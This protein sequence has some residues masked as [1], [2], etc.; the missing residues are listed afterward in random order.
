[1]QAAATFEQIAARLASGESWTGELEMRRRDGSTFAGLIVESPLSDDDGKIIGSVGVAY[2]LTAQ[3]VVQDELREHKVQLADAQEIA[4]IGSWTFDFRTGQRHWSDAL[5]QLYGLPPGSQPSIEDLFSLIHP[6][7]R[8]RVIEVHRQSH[9]D[10]LPVTVEF[11]II[12]NGDV[13]SIVTRVRFVR[14]ELGRPA[15][16]LVV[17]QDVTEERARE[18]ELRRRTFQQSAVANLGQLALSG[19]SIEFLLEQVAISVQSVVDV[20]VATVLRSDDEVFLLV[21]GAGWAADEIGRETIPVRARSHSALTIEAGHPI[22]MPDA[23]T[24][25]RFTLSDALR[26]KGAVSGIFVPIHSADG[27]AW[28][29]LG[30][31]ATRSRAY[32]PH[33]VEFLTAVSSIIGQAIDRER[34][35]LELRTRS[36]RQSAI[37]RLGQLVL[38]DLSDDV[39]EHA[40]E[41]MM[42]GLE[43][44]FG[45]F[46][47]VLPG[48]RWRLR[49]GKIWLSVESEGPLLPSMQ[50]GEAFL[51]SAA[52]VVDDYTTDTRFDAAARTVPYGI[53]SGLVVPVSSAS[54][55]FGVLSVQSR[56]PRHFGQEEVDFAQTIAHMLAEAM[57][58]QLSRRVIEESEHRYRRIF[59]GAK[60]I[61]FTLDYEGRFVALNPA[62]ETLTGWDRQEWIGRPFVELIVPEDRERS[63]ALFESMLRER[64]AANAQM[65]LIGSDRLV[66]VD[67]SS[68]PKTDNGAITE[69][70]GFARD[71]TDTRRATAERERVTRNLELLL[72]STVDGIYTLDM[73][74][75]CTMINRAAAAMLQRTPEELIG[76]KLHDL[77]HPMVPVSECAVLRVLQTAEP[78]TV[79]NDSFVKNDG[80]TFP[81]AHSAAP[82]ID[83]GRSVGVVVTFTD[84]SET[85][86]LE[87][88]LD[89]ANRLSSLG[90]LAA[91]VAHEFNNVL[92]GIAP[93]IEVI[94]RAPTPQKIEAS[95][96]HIANSVKRG[97]RITQDIL[98]FTQPAEPVRARVDVSSWLNAVAIEARSVLPPI[99]SLS[100][101]VER[102]TIE[103]DANQLHQVVMNLVLNA[104]D[105]MPSGGR[106]S[107]EARR[108][109]RNASFPFGTIQ[110]P[111]GY[112]HLLVRDEGMGMSPETLH[113]AFEPLFTTKRNGTGLGL[114]VTHQVVLR[115]QGEIFIESAVGEGT[116]FHIFLPLEEEAVTANAATQDELPESLPAR[117]LLLVED[118]TTV[119]EGL[120]SLLELEGFAVEKADSGAEALIQVGAKPFDV[121]LLDVGLPD[122]DGRAVYA[123]IAERYPTLPVIFSTGHADR[124]QLEALLT[125]P[126][127]DMLL[128]PYEI[129]SLMDV[130]GK[131]M[132]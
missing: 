84:L 106:I 112:V 123:R 91:T 83:D 21:A 89:Q 74:G 13:R 12:R 65:T 76:R 25:T 40:C 111:S 92:M 16:A 116:T 47:D 61:I 20:D 56:K 4:R 37:A 107:I 51:T 67:V 79:A 93:F 57:D 3:K 96:D 80:S 22:V 70:Y 124:A 28:G 49:A 102:V 72:A 46:L 36:R 24:E 60:E 33:E 15:K 128:K 41:V 127:V 18:E 44:D 35:E 132:A 97:R 81:V 10:L 104:R 73:D 87:A 85:R 78:C 105:A 8:E 114:A 62:F 90:R 77:L 19:A 122:M 29:V 120:I 95:L 101:A 130:L 59:D 86:K 100:T 31:D 121:V 69:V 23:A 118:D 32:L 6:D 109:R 1:M 63:L 5:R 17:M 99:Y 27:T 113:H 129:D 98:R 115:H 42:E 43:A 2:D 103:G 14:D 119:A 45:F 26:R 68:F 53:R 39:F 52:V 82:I 126:H 7:D 38:D 50:T 125:T 94:R 34:A 54:T 58:R 9:I 131:V 48:N 117:R 75:R 110:D 55:K 11:R 64:T 30:A 66:C 88:R 108:E 71:I